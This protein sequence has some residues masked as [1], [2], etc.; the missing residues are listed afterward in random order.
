L[1]VR[2]N[3]AA[4]LLAVLGGT[5]ATFYRPAAPA[6]QPLPQPLPLP[7]PLPLTLSIHDAVLAHD[8]DRVRQ[9]ILENPDL[10]NARTEKGDTPLYIASLKGYKQMVP[11][12]LQ[13][14]ADPNPAPNSRQETPL[15]IAREFNMSKT[16]AT[17]I[18]A[19]AR[20]DD[21]SRGAQ[22]RYLA[23]KRD[24]VALNERLA[25]AR[26]LVNAPDAYGQTPLTLAVGADKADLNSVLVLLNWGADPNVT[27][28][29]G[30]TPYSVAVEREHT[31]LVTLLKQHGGK[32]TPITRSAP[33]RSAARKNLLVELE[34]QL[35]QH[36]DW[37]N[38]PDDM[39]R[40]PL[41]YA[42]FAGGA[43]IVSLLL[44]HGADVNR[45]D[46]ADNTALQ[47]AAQAGHDEVVAAL[48]A[49]KADPNV[50]NRQQMTPLLHAVGRGS[51]NAV[52]QL[53]RAGADPKAANNLGQTVLHA[54]AGA[55]SV[56]LVKLCLERGLD[57]N[58]RDFQRSTPLHFAALRG[59]NDVVK[60]LLERKAN[61]TLKDVNGETPASLSEK[62]KQEETAKLLRPPP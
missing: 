41:H 42:S 24:S 58:C 38:A 61:P 23:T 60:L 9:L 62:R 56:E 43:K 40:P 49:A 37:A 48:L 30:G 47:I 19:G 20:E 16:A 7:L 18:S 17:L 34:T 8:L 5:L 1:K 54:A 13:L 3:W 10:V 55:G 29:F 4:I 33:L 21:R 36:P 22:L 25:Q 46:F 15:S 53:L 28:Q 2:L 11:L 6:P 51:T 44:Q 39:L 32:E 57:V 14:G 12:L 26:H 27:N 50:R 52:A 35:K 31:N 59:N 45:R